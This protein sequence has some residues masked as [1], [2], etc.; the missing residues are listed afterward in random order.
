MGNARAAKRYAKAVFDLAE[1]EGRT[2]AVLADFTALAAL[3]EASA[4][5]RQFADNY[6][7]EP[8]RR[9]QTLGS[10]F[11][12]RLDPLAFKFLVF[13]DSKRR[14]GEIA[15]VIR[16]FHRL[17]DAARGV[18]DVHVTS[19]APLTDGQADDLRGRLRTRFQRE[20][21]PRFSVKPGLIGGFQIQVNDLVYDDSIEYQLQSLNRK[22]ANA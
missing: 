1:E 5:L 16:E 17:H 12:G 8:A 19:A 9:V 2:D 15:E 20:I 6:M 13:L 21:K 14:F 3:L 10:L 11:E 7:I 4:D 18:L 22:L